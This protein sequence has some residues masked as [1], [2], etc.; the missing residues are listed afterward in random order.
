MLRLTRLRRKPRIPA[1]TTTPDLVHKFASLLL[2]GSLTQ[3]V[4]ASENVPHRPFADWAGVP[5]RG[6]FVLGLVYEESEAYH[7]W[8]GGQYQDVTVKS[9]GESHGIDINQGYIAL[10][11]GITEHQSADLNAGGITAG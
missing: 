10:Q 7:I 3:T 5:G 1:P 6:Q 8:A 2:L 11:Y 9:D 4:L